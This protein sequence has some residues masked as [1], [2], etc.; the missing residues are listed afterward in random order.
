MFLWSVLLCWSVAV[1][2]IW[3]PECLRSG[4]DH[5]SAEIP[6]KGQTRGPLY[7]ILCW[8]YRTKKILLKLERMKVKTVERSQVTTISK[9]QGTALTAYW[10]NFCRPGS[11]CSEDTSLFALVCRSAAGRRRTCARWVLACSCWSPLAPGSR[12]SPSKQQRKKNR[13]QVRTSTK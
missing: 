5:N 12:G 10:A 8:T 9:I 1:L 4:A 7:V 11:S 6:G 2:M 3:R 13:K